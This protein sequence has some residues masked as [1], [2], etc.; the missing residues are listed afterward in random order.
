MTIH[1]RLI[2][3]GVVVSSISCG[4]SGHSTRD[5]TT[6]SSLEFYVVKDEAQCRKDCEKV[7]FDSL[8]LGTTVFWVNQ[9]PDLVL[10][11]DD[12]TAII[13]VQLSAANIE[14][15]ETVVWTG[16]LRL[17]EEADARLR[18]LGSELTPQD[19][20]LASSGGEP[21]SVSY[22][23]WLGQMMGLGEFSSREELKETLG[24]YGKVEEGTGEVVE[25]F[26]SQELEANRRRH[27]LIENSETMQAE[28][29][30]IQRL[31]EEGKIS[32]AEMIERLT[33]LSRESSDK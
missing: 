20:I 18:R 13:P 9:R 11:P 1:H 27:Q 22:A 3:L 19:R 2:A 23:R 12:I 17:T 5:R 26:S 31:A 24:E 10:S 14:R 25:V 15:P 28:M 16:T 8:L 4:Y 21:L 7:T 6:P 33:E 29:E 32:R 30:K